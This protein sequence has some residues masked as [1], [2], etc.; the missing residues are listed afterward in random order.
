MGND[1]KQGNP[2]AD[3]CAGAIM[4]KP[5]ASLRNIFDQPTDRPTKTARCREVSASKKKQ[6]KK[7]ANSGLWWTVVDG[8]TDLPTDMTGCGVT[9]PQLKSIS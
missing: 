9:C 3:G 8:W 1:E 6:T 7:L 2:I 4:Q 5:L